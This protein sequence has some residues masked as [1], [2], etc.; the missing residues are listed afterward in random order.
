M[1]HASSVL[2]KCLP[3]PL[4]N[5]PQEKLLSEGSVVPKPWLKKRIL[6]LKAIENFQISLH[7]NPSIHT[8]LLTCQDTY[9]TF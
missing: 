1:G 9:A 3:P 5:T 4:L 6:L 8:H 2:S 7:Y